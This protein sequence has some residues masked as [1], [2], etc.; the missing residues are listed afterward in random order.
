ME[1]EFFLL[2]VTGLRDMI[3]NTFIY[4]ISLAA[5]FDFI[6]G[7]CCGIF[8]VAMSSSVGFKGFI[9]TT[10]LLLFIYV[11][12]PFMYVLNLST[13][14]D[15]IIFSYIFLYLMSI[16]ENAVALGVPVPEQVYNFVLDSH[17]KYKVKGKDVILEKKSKK[18]KVVK[19]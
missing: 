2:I 3:N 1:S 16:L 7:T 6:L 12:Y 9:R 17:D 14:M 15:V 18:R 11:S 4:V 10:L 5:I 8:G 19:K 13:I